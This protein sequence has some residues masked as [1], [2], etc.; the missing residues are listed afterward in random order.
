MV[1]EC[2]K[3][4]NLPFHEFIASTNGGI[5]LGFDEN[6]YDVINELWLENDDELLNGVILINNLEE[7]FIHNAQKNLGNYIKKQTLEISDTIVHL[8]NIIYVGEFDIS[9]YLNKS[10]FTAKFRIDKLFSRKNRDAL[11]KKEL[12]RQYNSRIYKVFNS[13]DMRNIFSRQIIMPDLDKEDIRR[14]LLNSSISEYQE[15]LSHLDIDEFGGFT[16][17][18]VIDYI[19]SS[20]NESPLKLNAI[21]PILENLYIDAK[22]HVKKP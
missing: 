22:K 13:R 4:L 17:K 18:E 12:W 14:V 19:V 3:E 6:F 5:D 9:N 20:V 21:S 16:N 11:I 8:D 2:A 10:N 15:F 1:R 7:I